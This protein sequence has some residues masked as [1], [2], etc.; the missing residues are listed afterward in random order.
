MKKSLALCIVAYVL[1]GIIPF[2]ID[3]SAQ[4]ESYVDITPN[5]GNVIRV[6]DPKEYV[7]TVNVVFK[8]PSIDS[9]TLEKINLIHNGGILSEKSIQKTLHGVKEKSEELRTASETFKAMKESQVSK[10]EL[11]IQYEKVKNL[12]SEIMKE[13]HIEIITINPSIIFSNDFPM[14]NQQIVNISVEVLHNG[15]K[16]IITKDVIIKILPPLPA[17]P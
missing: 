4:I 17:I 11:I 16:L 3:L 14:G 1:V 12:E 5:I 2:N 6:S 10:G 8:G 9:I 13:T 7:G 15:E